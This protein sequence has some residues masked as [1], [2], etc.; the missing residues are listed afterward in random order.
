MSQFIPFGTRVS[1]TRAMFRDGSSNHRGHVWEAVDLASPASGVLVGYR[2]KQ[3]G[4][5]AYGQRLGNARIQARLLAVR[6]PRAGSIGS[7]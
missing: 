3:N 5:M 2:Y 4:R 1:Y 6:W 7:R